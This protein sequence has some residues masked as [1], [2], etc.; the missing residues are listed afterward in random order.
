MAFYAGHQSLGQACRNPR[1]F[2]LIVYTRTLFPNKVSGRHEF[3][4]G[5]QYSYPH[6]IQKGSWKKLI[7]REVTLPGWHRMKIK[8]WHLMVFFL[9]LETVITPRGQESTV[10]PRKRWFYLEYT[11]VGMPGW[12]S[13]W[14][15]A[16]GSG[17]DPR[18]LGFSPTSGFPARSLLLSLPMSLPLSLCL[19]WIH[20]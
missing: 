4:G 11:I 16:Y 20:K 9:L 15:S 5:W 8:I 12:L 2:I 10:H 18:V 13:G 1:D 3:R 19:S 7:I 14:V 6:V 17:H